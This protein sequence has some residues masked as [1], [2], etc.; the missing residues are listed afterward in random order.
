MKSLR[1]GFDRAKFLGR[2]SPD[3]EDINSGVKGGEWGRG[4]QG[5]TRGDGWMTARKKKEEMKK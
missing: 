1:E 3:I 5:S 2:G 4:E